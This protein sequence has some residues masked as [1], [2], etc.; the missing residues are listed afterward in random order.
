MSLTLEV[1][2]VHAASMGADVRRMLGDTELKIGRDSDNDWILPQSY[3]SRHQAVVRCVN[4]M[5]FLEQVGSCPIV[6]NE[7]GRPLE[8]N[9]IARLSVGDRIMIDDIEIRVQESDALWAA[10]ASVDVPTMFPAMAAAPPLIDSPLSHGGPI[11]PLELLGVRAPDPRRAAPRLPELRSILDEAMAPAPAPAVSPAVA[12]APALSDNWFG[13]ASASRSAPAMPAMSPAPPSRAAPPSGAPAAG[14]LENLL[15]GAGLDPAQTQLS[16]EVASQLGEVFRIVV[17]GTMQVLQARNQ[18]RKEFRMATTQVAQRNNNPLKFSADVA[19]ALHKLLVQRSPAY[20]DTV[21]SFAD[22]FDDIRVHQFA[23]L[24]SLRVA[25]DYMLSQFDPEV[26]QAQFARQGGR[27]SVLG[28]GGKPKLWEAYVGRYG[29]L[30][31]DRDFA[32]RRLFGEEFGKA[33]EQN[34]EQQRR[35]LEANKNVK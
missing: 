32:F 25:F 19:D 15:R 1:V 22:A 4:G 35:V 31:A 17:E 9:R 13:G 30:T 26:L 18:I 16:E 21:S 34:L 12:A 8:R 7:T 5:Y 27:G 29:E 14:T 6:L 33:Y 10:P 24:A 20:L 28:L 23:M 11:D 2:G 3:V